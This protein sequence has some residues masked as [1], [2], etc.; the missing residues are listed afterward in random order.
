MIIASA[1]PYPPCH[2]SDAIV[3]ETL[4]PDEW[5]EQTG[6]SE[7]Q[8]AFIVSSYIHLMF[9]EPPATVSDDEYNTWHDAHVQE[10]LSVEGWESATRY[11]IQGVVGA[12]G[13]K[14]LRFLSVYELSVPPD[15]AVANLA[16]ANMG[17]GEGRLPL[18]HWFTAVEFAAW[19]C[20][21]VSE[22]ITVRPA[23]TSTR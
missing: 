2:T 12:D 7:K 23:A 14:K 17:N 3:Y 21:Q 15:V 22:R 8:E 5:A 4:A 20:T 9:S 11:A 18:P 1:G 6:D 13:S 10:I 16:A 19:N